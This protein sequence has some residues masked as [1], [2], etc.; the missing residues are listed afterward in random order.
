MVCRT[1]PIRVGDT[2]TG[3]T[4]GPM[5]REISLEVIASRSQIPIEELRNTEK[6]STTRRKRRI[7]E[8]DWSQFQRSAMLNGPSDIALTFADYLGVAN[9]K[10]YRYEQLSEDALRFIE[11]LEKVGGVPVSLVSTGFNERNIIDRR[12]W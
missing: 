7:A 9:R 12:A 4:S 1:Y 3:K 10:A 6:T 8:F 2:D 5:S 11:E